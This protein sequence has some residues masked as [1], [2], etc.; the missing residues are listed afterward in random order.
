M[1]KSNSIILGCSMF[2]NIFGCNIENGIFQFTFIAFCTI[3]GFQ[4]YCFLTID[5]KKRWGSFSLTWKQRDGWSHCLSNSKGSKTLE[6][7]V[8]ISGSRELQFDVIPIL[9]GLE[10][11][12]LFQPFSSKFR[13]DHHGHRWHHFQIRFLWAETQLLHHRRSV[14]GNDEALHRPGYQAS[15]RHY[16]WLRRDWKSFWPRCRGYTKCWRFVLWTF[17]R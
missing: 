11:Q 7:C 8:S 4:S 15:L 13:R 16:F 10:S 2:N 5:V 1:I 12:Q 9:Q 14:Q 3:R 17:P 6:F